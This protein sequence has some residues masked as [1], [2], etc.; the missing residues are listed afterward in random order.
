MRVNTS[1]SST[2]ISLPWFWFLLARLGCSVFSIHFF[3]RFAVQLVAILASETDGLGECRIIL[4]CANRTNSGDHAHALQA[5]NFMPQ[6]VYLSL[7]AREFHFQFRQ[8]HWSA[9]LR[10]ILT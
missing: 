6:G 1:V 4:E 9:L 3:Q 10:S 5:Q 7:K 2:S 8:C